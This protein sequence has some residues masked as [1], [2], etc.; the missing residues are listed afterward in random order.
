MTD[1]LTRDRAA[2]LAEEATDCLAFEK[3]GGFSARAVR[4][5]TRDQLADVARELGFPAT[6]IEAAVDAALKTAGAR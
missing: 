4:L 5:A 1:A 2:A 3:L 6:E